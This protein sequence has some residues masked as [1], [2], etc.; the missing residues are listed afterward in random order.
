MTVIIVIVSFNADFRGYLSQ[1]FEEN[2]DDQEL[3]T[4]S[5]Q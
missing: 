2:R 1:N 4:V 5:A 3:E